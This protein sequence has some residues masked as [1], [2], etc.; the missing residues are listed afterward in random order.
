MEEVKKKSPTQ[1]ASRKYAI[2]K[3]MCKQTLKN[4]WRAQARSARFPHF[5]RDG[6]RRRRRVLQVITPGRLCDTVCV[7]YYIRSI[8]CLFF[9]V[10]KDDERRREDP[11]ASRDCGQRN[12]TTKLVGSKWDQG[13]SRK[14]RFFVSFGWCRMLPW[15]AGCIPKTAWCCCII[16]GPV[17]GQRHNL[18]GAV[19]WQKL[20]CLVRFL[21]FQWFSFSVENE[22]QE[23]RRAYESEAK[24]KGVDSHHV[25]ERC[26]SFSFGV[27]KIRSGY[28][29]HTHTTGKKEISKGKTGQGRRME[30]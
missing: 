25:I 26:G 28:R 5:T 23:R 2:G 11:L 19:V 9:F 20:L 16:C 10:G 27:S 7:A 29:T 3:Q 15:L 24:G 30:E 22:N 13:T 8:W 1:S 21:F 4:G 6:G 14:S 17:A 18:F 12:N